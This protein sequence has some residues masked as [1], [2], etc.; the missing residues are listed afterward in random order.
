VCRDVLAD[1]IANEFLIT[2]LVAIESEAR[3]VPLRTGS[4]PRLASR[5]SP[6]SS[7]MLK[8]GKFRRL[9]SVREMS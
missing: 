5:N 9:R 4:E 6:G 2:E 3:L 8:R 1:D 7:G